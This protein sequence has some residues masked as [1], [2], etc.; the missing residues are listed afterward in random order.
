MDNLWIYEQGRAVPQEAQKQIGAGRLKGMTD[1]NPM[2]R[3]QK[4][5]ELFGPCGIGWKIEITDKRLETGAAGEVVAVVDANL[6]IKQEDTWS[7][8][9]PGT[10]GSMLVTSE[11]SGLHTSDE[12]YKMAY[13][14]AISVCCK[15]LGIGADIYW[16]QGRTKFNAPAEPEKPQRLHC[17]ACG[18]PI[19]PVNVKGTIYT[20]EQIAENS[21]NTYGKVLCWKCSKAEAR[22]ENTN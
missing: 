12:A 4:L 15:L 10:G 18:K 6:Y 2:W 21:K 22:R 7:A 11:R 19:A 17:S 20:A 14:D 5:T 3:I 9:I 13:T 8:P 16:A 1:I